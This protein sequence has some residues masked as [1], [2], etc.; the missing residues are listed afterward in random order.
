MI[1]LNSTGIGDEISY[2]KT[3]KYKFHAYTM[4]LNNF[5][6]LYLR[7][8]CSNYRHGELHRTISKI[9]GLVEGFWN[10]HCYIQNSTENG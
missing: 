5:Q 4:K 6:Y 7:E 8:L 1:T 9:L 3:R 2:T 10:S